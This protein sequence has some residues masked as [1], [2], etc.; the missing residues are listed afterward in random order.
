[1]NFFF[2]STRFFYQFKHHSHENPHPIN[3]FFTSILTFGKENP[4]RNEN[5]QSLDQGKAHHSHYMQ[6]TGQV[7][8]RPPMTHT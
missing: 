2:P 8:I 6:K 1:M 4:S 3:L 5:L 7:A